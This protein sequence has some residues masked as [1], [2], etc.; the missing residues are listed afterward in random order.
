MPHL[1]QRIKNYFTEQLLPPAAFE[2]SRHYLSG[3]HFSIKE[4]KV[5]SHFISLLKGGTLEPSFDKTNI[6]NASSLGQ[7]LKEGARRLHYSG[8]SVSLLLPESCLKVF[9]FSFDNLPSAAK[10]KEEFIRWRLAKLIPLR[11]ADLQISFNIIPS[12]NHQK[13]I[14][15]LARTETIG[16]YESFFTGH[17]FKVRFIGIPALA[18]LNLIN[19]KE[20]Q[21]FML[22]NLGEDEMSLAVVLN[23]ELALYRHK[24]F[25]VDTL[26]AMTGTER[27]AQALNEIEN[28][29]HFIEDKEKRKINSIWLRSTSLEDEESCL[30]FLKEKISLPLQIIQPAFPLNLSLREK[31]LLSPLLGQIS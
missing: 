11:G 18:L 3:I 5:K 13:V 6:L 26:Q 29:I 23:S 17:G 28:T 30:S 31:Q 9:V 15:T 7:K 19:S 2:L 20:A 25:L 10:E 8:N 21:D 1:F 24:T 12:N 22:V 4:K 16:E 27:T 14:L